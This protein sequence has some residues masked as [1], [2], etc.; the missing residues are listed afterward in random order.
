MRESQR[1]DL[2]TAVT[3]R[4]DSLDVGAPQRARSAATTLV[5]RLEKKNL[6]F[7]AQGQAIV[8]VKVRRTTA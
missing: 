7:D 3:P 1:K 5:V 4:R 6:E 8:Q 2:H